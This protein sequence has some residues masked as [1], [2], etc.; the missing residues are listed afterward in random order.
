MNNEAR[1][2][3]NWFKTHTINQLELWIDE[4]LAENKEL[5]SRE[6]DPVQPSASEEDIAKALAWADG[7]IIAETGDWARRTLAAALRSRPSKPASESA[8]ELACPIE[9]MEQLAEI[10]HDRWSEQARTALDEMTPERRERWD[11]L[12]RIKYADLDEHNKEL[13]RMQVREYWP[14]IARIIVAHDAETL[15]RAESRAMQVAIDKGLVRSSREWKP[16]AA[17]I[18]NE[19]KDGT[20]A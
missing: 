7:G 2:P 18:M 1:S 14:L 3:N 9:L 10:E 11:R 20:N 16:I 5:R 15:R 19:G 12:S 6:P 8:E 4:L 17:A 13:D